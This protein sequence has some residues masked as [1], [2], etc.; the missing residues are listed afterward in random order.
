MEKLL[1]QAVDHHPQRRFVGYQG[2]DSP[3]QRKLTV[4]EQVRAIFT[5][6]KKDAN[7]LYVNSPLNFGSQGGQITQRVRL[8]REILEAGGSANCIDGTVL[9]ASLL[10]LATLDPAIVLIHGH[11][12]VGWRQWHNVKR[13]NFLETTAIGYAEF[14]AACEAAEVRF[15]KVKEAGD[16]DRA[17]FDPKGFARL[18][19]VAECRQQGIYPL[20]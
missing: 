7:L 5:A 18:I 3:V 4:R 17:L 15:T 9:F 1:R 11:A 10:E 16:L 13:Y 19:D 2:P 14:E 20:E 8:P 12:F 6:L